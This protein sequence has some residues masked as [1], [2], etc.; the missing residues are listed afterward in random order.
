MMYVNVIPSPL[1]R[2]SLDKPYYAASGAIFHSMLEDVPSNNPSGKPIPSQSDI[3]SRVTIRIH[4]EEPGK[5]RDLLGHLVDLTHI[6][7]KRGEV[8]AF[9]PQEIVVWKKLES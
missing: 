3:G 5:F 6:Q 1:T 4:D 8:K 9:N 2:Y 7:D